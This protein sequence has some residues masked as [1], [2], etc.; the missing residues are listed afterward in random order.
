MDEISR[1]LD[2]IEKGI[3]S[4]LGRNYLGMNS[5]LANGE[6]YMGGD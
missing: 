4:K 3:Q 1:F 5:F 6:V 2:I